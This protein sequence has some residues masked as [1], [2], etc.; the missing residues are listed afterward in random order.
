VE[1]FNIFFLSVLTTIMHWAIDAEVE[2]LR[3]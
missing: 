2:Y 3:S 1:L